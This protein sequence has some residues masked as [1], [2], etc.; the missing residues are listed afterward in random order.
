MLEEGFDLS[1][2]RS[3]WDL[4]ENK[5]V[6]NAT[7]NVIGLKPIHV[8]L[9]KTK[10]LVLNFHCDC[11]HFKTNKGCKHITGLLYIG[12]IKTVRLKPVNEQR[13][14]GF[15]ELFDVLNADELGGFLKFYASN[16]LAF[17][18][19]FK[20][21]FSYKFIQYGLSFND[22]FNQIIQSHMDVRGK[23]SIKSKKLICQI[24]ELHLFRT[25][26]LLRNNDWSGALD[27]IEVIINRI[28]QLDFKEPAKNIEFIVEKSHNNLM[29]IASQTIA[30]LLKRKITKISIEL[31]AL[32]NYNYFKHDNAVELAR[33]NLEQNFEI[34]KNLLEEK[35][36]VNDQKKSAGFRHAPSSISCP[37]KTS[38]NRHSSGTSHRQASQGSRLASIF[39]QSRRN[40]SDFRF[41]FFPF[42]SAS[43]RIKRRFFRGEAKIVAP[44]LAFVKERH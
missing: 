25:D 41:L 1:Q 4:D 3:D 29:A 8:T 30:P 21:Y 9:N 10:H 2:K 39:F 18:K 11:T 27:I 15:E 13:K 34:V 24:F 6:T 37:C 32:R 33:I 22:Y 17:N 36:S 16:N 14:V 40:I 31:I 26:H 7:Y 38:G 43:F 20:Q 19:L 12:Q 44:I 5:G 28:Y 35:I 23:Y 42:R